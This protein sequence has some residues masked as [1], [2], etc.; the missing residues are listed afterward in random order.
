MPDPHGQLTSMAVD[1]PDAVAD[2]ASLLGLVCFAL[3]PYGFLFGLLTLFGE[4]LR[5][6][7]TP[8][9]IL[10]LVWFVVLPAVTGSTPG[11]SSSATVCPITTTRRPCALSSALNAEPDASG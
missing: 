3:V 11:N 4:D 2:L 6:R 7:D 9:V 8:V 5:H 1:G 10:A